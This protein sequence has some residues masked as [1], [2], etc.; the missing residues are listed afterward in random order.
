MSLRTLV[1]WGEN[2]L[3]LQDGAQAFCWAFWNRC[4]ET[5]R[6]LV[7][8]FYQRCFARELTPDRHAFCPG[9]LF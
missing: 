4:D 3:L 9:S 8:E 7:A 5:E 2:L 6:P 1:A